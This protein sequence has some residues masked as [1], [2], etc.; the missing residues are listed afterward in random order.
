MSLLY[1]SFGLR[2]ACAVSR[3]ETTC[4]CVRASSATLNSRKNFQVIAIYS[5]ILSRLSLGFIST[6]FFKFLS[7]LRALRSLFLYRRP[8]PLYKLL[9]LFY[10][11]SVQVLPCGVCFSR[12]GRGQFI[13][14]RVYGFFFRSII[15]REILDF[16]NTLKVARCSA[17]RK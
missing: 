15:K 3:Y 4:V 5:V 12:V 9:I 2:S 14:C 17:S 8:T 16:L 10:N 11:F 7:P 6:F 1:Y 13:L